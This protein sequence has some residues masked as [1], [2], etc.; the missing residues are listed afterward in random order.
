VL[1]LPTRESRLA[2]WN[3]HG[4]FYPEVRRPKREAGAEFKNEWCC[5]PAVRWLCDI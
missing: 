2:L 3:V 5:R 1:R 4:A